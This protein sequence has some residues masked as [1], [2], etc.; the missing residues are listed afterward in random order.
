MPDRQVDGSTRITRTSRQPPSPRNLQ[1][2]C[3]RTLTIGRWCPSRPHDDGGTSPLSPILA[4]SVSTAD[5]PRFDDPSHDHDWPIGTSLLEKSP[6][7]PAAACRHL[8]IDLILHQAPASLRAGTRPETT[9][10]SPAAETSSGSRDDECLSMSQGIRRPEV[11]ASGS[12]IVLGPCWSRLINCRGPSW[13]T[14]LIRV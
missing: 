14:F 12:N 5:L 8:P 9:R 11:S 10:T 1:S 7:A 3:N 4:F 13:V 2:V 6:R